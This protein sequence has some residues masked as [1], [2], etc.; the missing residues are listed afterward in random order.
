MTIFVL[1]DY[2]ARLAKP[3]DVFSN[4]IKGKIVSGGYDSNCRGSGFYASIRPEGSVYGGGRWFHRDEIGFV[5]GSQ[6]VYYAVMSAYADQKDVG[7][8]I[9]NEKPIET[10]QI[11]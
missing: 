7:L 8:F 1:N 10:I 9:E 6:D 3:E 11:K 2:I 4:I 5:I